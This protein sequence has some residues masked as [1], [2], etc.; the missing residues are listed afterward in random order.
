MYSGILQLEKFCPVVELHRRGFATVWDEYPCYGRMNIRIY[1]LP[2]ILDKWISE[3]IWHDKTITNKY[4][5]RFALEKIKKYICE[6]IYLSKLFE[7]IQISDN[8]PKNVLNYDGHFHILCYFVP[9]FSHFG[10]IRNILKHFWETM[11][12]QI[13]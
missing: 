9:I 4:P 1:S 5:N 10:T 3:H 7:Y 8:L 6:W 12:I 13:Y 11:K 2:Y